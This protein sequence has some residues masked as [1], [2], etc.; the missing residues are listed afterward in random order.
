MGMKCILASYLFLCHSALPSTGDQTGRYQ[1]T[2]DVST[3]ASLFPPKELDSH[4]E[5]PVLQVA[6]CVSA[7]LT[8]SLGSRAT[9]V[10]VLET[11]RRQK[12][13]FLKDS[14]TTILLS[15]YFLH[16]GG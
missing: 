9:Q 16:F 15:F 3:V 4:R 8:L 14:M 10:P 12:Q 7:T 2:G 6:A 5:P 13:R 1:R 11:D